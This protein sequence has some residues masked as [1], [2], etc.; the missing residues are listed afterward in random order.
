M[1]FEG[2]IYCIEDRV[3]SHGDFLK[4]CPLFY[5]LV[6]IID[7]NRIQKTEFRIKDKI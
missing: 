6:R 4:I 2:S 7:K 5:V 1:I 3:P